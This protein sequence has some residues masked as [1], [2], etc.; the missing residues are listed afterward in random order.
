MNLHCLNKIF[1]RPVKEKYI[2]RSL[3]LASKKSAVLQA[4]VHLTLIKIQKMFDSF[5]NLHFSAGATAPSGLPDQ[6]SQTEEKYKIRQ[7]IP[8]WKSSA[9]LT[10][11][12][13]D[14][15][16]YFTFTFFP[17]ESWPTVWRGPFPGLNHPTEK[18][19]CFPSGLQWASP[20]N[21]FSFFN[22]YIFLAN[23]WSAQSLPPPL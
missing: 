10:G 20:A 16:L 17:P 6:G 19:P 18:D 5:K 4:T 9:L 1:N 2:C 8:M 23:R 12:A 13:N 11:Q 7:N 3:L 14:F 15:C 21:S 22:A